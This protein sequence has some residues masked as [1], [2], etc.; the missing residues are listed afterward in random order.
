MIS[1]V[2]REYLSCIHM[3]NL[4]PLSKVIEYHGSITIIIS[5]MVLFNYNI[6]DGPL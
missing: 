2:V 6:L 5:R 4:V 3:V 1:L